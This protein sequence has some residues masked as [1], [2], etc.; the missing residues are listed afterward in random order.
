MS[1]N[2]GS[3]LANCVPHSVDIPCSQATSFRTKTNG[4]RCVKFANRS[5]VR[6]GVEL[7]VDEVSELPPPFH[8]SDPNPVAVV[9]KGWISKL[10]R[11]DH[12]RSF[13]YKLLRQ[14]AVQLWPQIFLVPVLEKTRTGHR[15]LEFVTEVF[16]IIDLSV[17][18]SRLAAALR[19]WPTNA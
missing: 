19:R 5:E 4:G 11:R 1:K 6:V 16:A 14:N 13:F 18:L 2:M 7:A 10:R 3:S 17:S 8:T 15:R 9:I 12:K